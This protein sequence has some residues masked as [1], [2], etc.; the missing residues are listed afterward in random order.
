MKVRLGHVSNSSTSSFFGIGISRSSI[1]GIKEAFRPDP[2][3]VSGDLEDLDNEELWEWLTE[4]YGNASEASS[5]L[6]SAKIDPTNYEYN[7][8]LCACYTTMDL[9][10]TKREFIA[11]VTKAL[12]TVFDIKENSVGHMDDAWRDG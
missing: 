3:D 4:S 10:E 6:R 12:E 9:D 11:R 5:I 2:K 8:G 7:D 1:L